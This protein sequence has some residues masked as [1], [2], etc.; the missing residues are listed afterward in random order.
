MFRELRPGTRNGNDRERRPKMV[1]N[2]DSMLPEHEDGSKKIQAGHT[3][4]NAQ[5]RQAASGQRPAP[6]PRAL[7]SGDVIARGSQL[8]TRLALVPR[9]SAVCLRHRRL[10][11]CRH[12]RPQRRSPACGRGAQAA[13]VQSSCSSRRLNKKHGSPSPTACS[14]P[15]P[16][17]SAAQPRQRGSGRHGVRLRPVGLSSFGVLSPNGGRV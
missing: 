2:V 15:R 3:S 6:P 9:P 10:A 13:I 7:D 4:V 11:T 14:T 16:C 5:G 12:R 1:W 17:A 8:A